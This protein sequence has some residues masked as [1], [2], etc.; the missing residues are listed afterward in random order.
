MPRLDPFRRLPAVVLL[1]AAA[2]ACA[3]TAQ[4]PAPGLAG[5]WYFERDD[6]ARSLRLPWGVRLGEDSLAGWPALE[7]HDG[8]RVAAT[9]T[10]D[11]D[12]DHP[13]GYWRPLGEDSVEIGYPGGGGYTLRVGVEDQRLE[14]TVRAV[15]DARGP[16]ADDSPP[17]V[18]QPVALMR[19][20]CPE[21]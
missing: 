10:P 20:L 15:G 17:P 18:P 6:V 11:G 8:T 3:S 1:L 2:T 5:C 9:L 16:G 14:G 12:A 7:R 19:A 4:A 21:E 13:F